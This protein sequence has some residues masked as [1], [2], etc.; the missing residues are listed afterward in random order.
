MFL[1]G[2]QTFEKR[3][4]FKQFHDN[5]WLVSI[6][7]DSVNCVDV[8]MIQGGCGLRLALEPSQGD[9]IS[10]QLFWEELQCY[11]AA[12]FEVFGL[13]DHAHAAAADDLQDSIVRNPLSYQTS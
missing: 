9:R 12:Q 6:V 3:F 5:E 4:A 10:G 7:F 8:G 1:R 2:I 11:L 13:I